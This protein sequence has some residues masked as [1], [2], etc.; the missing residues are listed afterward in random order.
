MRLRSG[1][2]PLALEADALAA[3]PGA[4]PKLLI[5]VHGLCRCDLQWRRAN[6]HDHGA[7]LAR[8]LGYT[9]LYLHYNSG[10]HISRNG[11]D[12]AA[13]LEELVA[14]WPGRIDEIAILAHSM[15][16]LVA[17]SACHYGEQ[18]GHA[19]RATAAPPGI[20][21]HAAPRRAARTPRQLA[22]RRAGAQHVH[23]AVRQA[24]RT[25]QRR[26]HRSALRQP[27]R[28]RLAR[29]RPLRPWRRPAAA[30]AA[31]AAACAATPSPA[32]PA[33]ARAISATGCWATAWCRSTRRSAA[34]TIRRAP[35]RSRNRASGSA[36]ASIIWICSAAW[37]CTSRCGTGWRAAAP[38]LT[39]VVRARAA[40]ASRARQ[41]V[42][43]AG[44][45]SARS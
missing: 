6:H 10:R 8:D 1:G 21:R 45:A 17:R 35:W 43:T 42:R 40:C 41:G 20:S 5:L 23:G 19:W 39:P 38:A 32:P 31:A 13:L 36:S 25:A 16:G 30:A 11:R 18:A 33:G 2:K 28:R 37:K 24:G 15:G 29:A 12:L 22:H 34:T 14:N 7:A 44:T 27:G 3:L 4:G 26:H 9:P